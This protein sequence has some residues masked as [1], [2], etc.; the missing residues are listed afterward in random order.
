MTARNHTATR[1]RKTRPPITE[2]K[3]VTTR[4]RLRS[5]GHGKD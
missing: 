3:R 1:L 5:S 2:P 4:K